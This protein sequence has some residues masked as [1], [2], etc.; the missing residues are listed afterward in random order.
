[1]NKEK[2]NQYLRSLDWLLIKNELISTYLKEGWKIKCYCCKKTP[3]LQV[4]H[5]SYSN[6]G[7]EKEI[8]KD[9][10]IWEIGF[11]CGDCHKKWHFENNFKESVEERELKDLLDNLE[12]YKA[13]NNL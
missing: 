8:L 5:F 7:N 6:I 1:M 2:Y 10:R 4:H 3:N 12:Y 11:M 13:I 9:G